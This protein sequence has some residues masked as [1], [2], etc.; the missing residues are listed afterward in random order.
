MTPLQQRA[1][2]LRDRLRNPP[3]AVAD[4]G[5]NLRNGRPVMR[6]PYE[7]CRWSTPTLTLIWEVTPY[8]PPAFLPSAF[9]PPLPDPDAR[10]VSPGH[11]KPKA[12]AILV[13]NETCIAWGI[14]QFKLLSGRKF[15]EIVKPRW[16]AMAIV[17]RITPLS[18]PQIGEFFGG[19]DHATAWLAKKK[20]ADHIAA[21]NQELDD[22]STPA[23]WVRGLKARIEA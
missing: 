11:L 23:E 15:T 19:R 9:S 22:W 5:I 1:I 10:S 18:F 17:R 8:A 20:M 3:N 7:P 12:T 6:V 14:E 2:Q 16:A 13:I 4:T 21:L